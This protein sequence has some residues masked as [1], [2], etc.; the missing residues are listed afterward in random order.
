LGDV[1]EEADI[2]SGLK[3]GG[4]VLGAFI[5]ARSEEEFVVYMRCNWIRGRGFRIIRSWRGLSGDRTFKHLQSAWG[6][7]RKFDFLGRVTVYPAGDVE[8]RQF[9]GVAPQDLVELGHLA[10]PAAGSNPLVSAIA[11]DQDTAAMDEVHPAVPA[12][13]DPTAAVLDGTPPL[14]ATHPAAGVQ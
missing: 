7:I 4:Q 2:R 12:P 6:F 14:L 11:A 5:V 9:V 10:G 1:F 8:L 3:D 13:A